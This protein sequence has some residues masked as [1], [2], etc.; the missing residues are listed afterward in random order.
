MSR[1]NINR[2]PDDYDYRLYP[3]DFI[4]DSCEC[5][6]PFDEM[7]DN[8]KKRVQ[9]YVDEN[10]KLREENFKL[11][12]EHYKDT[13]IKKLNDY[14][15]GLKEDLYRG[16]PILKEEFDEIEKWQQS[17]TKKMHPRKPQKKIVKYLADSPDYNYSFSP[18]ELGIAQKCYC[19][20]C[21]LKAFKESKGDL[22]KYEDL[23]KKYDVEFDFST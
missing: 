5:V 4:D 21:R 18:F 13:E 8:I 17:H 10:K 3:D 2:F 1:K 15:E 16:F 14:I 6:H 12:S 20:T 11:K 19:E 7:F 22:E 23:L 9:K